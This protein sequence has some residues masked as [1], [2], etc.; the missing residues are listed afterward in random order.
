MRGLKGNVMDRR[1]LWIH[2]KWMKCFLWSLCLTLKRGSPQYDR[3]VETL[4]SPFVN[5]H[6]CWRDTSRPSCAQ[7]YSLSGCVRDWRTLL[8]RFLL[9]ED[10]GSFVYNLSQ[11]FEVWETS[12]S[13]TG[14]AV[15]TLRSVFFLHFKYFT[16]YVTQAVVRFSYNRHCCVVGPWCLL[17]R[18]TLG[19]NPS[20]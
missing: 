9:S 19:L 3:F 7:S 18:K 6:E 11:S 8:G 15:W 13:S 12:L 14:E 5:R 17:C 2:I 4:S 20:C 10:T 1:S 16:H